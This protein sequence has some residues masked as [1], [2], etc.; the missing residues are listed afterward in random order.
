V[1]GKAEISSHGTAGAAG[2][3]LSK[4]NKF[5]SKP[6][7]S[8]NFSVPKSYNFFSAKNKFALLQAPP[9]FYLHQDCNKYYWK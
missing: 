4:I 6:N 3:M 5:N 8:Y 1:A 9:I 2:A 7:S